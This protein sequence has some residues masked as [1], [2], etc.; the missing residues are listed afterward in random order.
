MNVVSDIL[1]ARANHSPGVDVF[2][3]LRVMDKGTPTDHTVPI[4]S[5][6][7]S[8]EENG[9]Y[10]SC[11]EQPLQL[12]SMKDLFLDWEVSTTL[13][14]KMHMSPKPSMMDFST[15]LHV[16]GVTENEH[17][18]QQSTDDVNQPSFFRGTANFN[19]SHVNNL[20]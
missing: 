13:L 8:V 17:D 3:V 16:E 14:K 18:T 2:S 12:I 5:I 1:A 10:V 19:T 6:I 15:T 20:L 4:S 11:R 9:S 7:A